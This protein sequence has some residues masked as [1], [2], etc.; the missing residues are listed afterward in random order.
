MMDEKQSQFINAKL[1]N[2][3]T[4]KQDDLKGLLKPMADMAEKNERTRIVKTDGNWFKVDFDV[5]DQISDRLVIVAERVHD[6]PVIISTAQIPI[7]YKIEFKYTRAAYLYGYYNNAH[8]IGRWPYLSWDVRAYATSP[9][10]GQRVYVQGFH[11]HEEIRKMLVK[12]NTYYGVRHIVNKYINDNLARFKAG[13]L[14]GKSPEMIEREWSRGMME[15]LGYSCVEAIDTSQPKGKW[16]GV[17]VHWFKNKNE[18][19]G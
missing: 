16:N 14:A 19:I 8:R 11:A 7:E 3:N 4:D 1:A 15:S 2:I 5:V 17:D 6:G 9:N 13:V 18:T 10:S 12:M